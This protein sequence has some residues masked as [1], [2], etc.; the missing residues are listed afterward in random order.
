LNR[1]DLK[2]RNLIQLL[3][4]LVI[5][6][7][8]G[9]L[10]S[11]VSFRIDLTS[12]KRYSLSNATKEIL[13]NL[14]DE[15]YVQ[16]YLD[17]DMPIGFKK[18]KNSL[19]DML[20]EFR[21]NSKRKIDY[22]FIDP[23]KSTDQKVRNDLFRELAVKG[24]KPTN[25]QVTE[26]DGGT[27]QKILFPG[28]ILNYKKME[29]AVNLLRNNPA[30]S[31]EQ[32][33]NHSIEGLEYE[34]I[35]SIKNISADTIHKVAFIE[36]HGEL[37]EY[38]VADITMELAR[39]YTVDRGVIGG[40][41][42]ILDNYS[43]I[44][45]AKPEN[46]FSEED[47]FVIDQ[48]IM[49][50]GKVLWL[51]DAVQVSWDS[52][53]YTSST[54]GMYH[55]LNIEDQLFKYGARINPI[56]IKDINSTLIPVNIALAGEQP[57]F[58]PAPWLYFPLII[59]PN[60]LP[61]TRNINPVKLEFV[62]PVDTVGG[63]PD[64]SKTYLLHSSQ[65]TST[66]NTPCLISLEEVQ[67]TPVEKDFDHS[68]IPIAVLLE[69]EFESLFKNRMIS[70]F[71]PS[72]DFDFKS[73]SSS[74]RMIIVADGDIIRNE[75]RVTGNRIIPLP[76]DQDRYTQQFYGNKDFIVNCVNYLI[77]ES[78]LMELRSRELKLRLLD[79]S[80][81]NKYQASLKLINTIFPVILLI[82]FGVVIWRIRKE[83]F[84]V[85]I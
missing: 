4:A 44:I 75:V 85:M 50:G 54:I 48:Y 16:I 42:G 34:L 80:K 61:I 24:L 72:S 28:L 84:E 70:E 38:Q 71:A 19:K 35:S 6:F 15:L 51:I 12:E 1:K 23:S 31:S 47:K 32:N 59:P 2:I 65:Y 67:Q 58:A 29:I 22:E 10:S 3:L 18:M 74:T 33:L 37:D 9:Y 62:S 49:N 63:N 45:I 5:M 43:A 40:A 46:R 55:P 68:F 25:V 39:F 82:L 36:G 64:I 76:L 77:D 73:L 81:L 21:A 66:V 56:L 60:N 53:V 7:L 17:G 27:S 26:K 30:L 8:V 52:L 11:L 57:E 83:K 69:G 14:E 20:D 79:R 78:D 13:K 41:P